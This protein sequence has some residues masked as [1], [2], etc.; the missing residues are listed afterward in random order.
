[1][2]FE[3][4]SRQGTDRRLDDASTQAETDAEQ[5][6]QTSAKEQFL[7]AIVLRKNAEVVAELRALL[8]GAPF[9]HQE[10]SEREDEGASESESEDE[11]DDCEEPPPPQQ[12]QQQ[13]QLVEAMQLMTHRE[14]S[15]ELMKWAVDDQ[16]IKELIVRKMF[17]RSHI[18]RYVQFGDVLHQE[19]VQLVME[20]YGTPRTTSGAEPD[21]ARR[22]SG[23]SD[24]PEGRRHTIDTSTIMRQLT[25]DEIIRHICALAATGRRQRTLGR[26]RSS[27]VSFASDVA[28]PSL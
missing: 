4:T 13:K 20:M 17:V 9:W 27:L 28:V 3:G 14:L 22:H 26:R 11:Q 21:E 8:T 24:T 25:M 16:E 2:P 7:D 19:R 1:M 5:Q 6:Q 10:E 12:Q 15:V 18:I 23:H